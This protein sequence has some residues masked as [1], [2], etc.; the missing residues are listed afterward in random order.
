ML[1]LEEMRLW[2]GTNVGEEVS[3]HHSYYMSK[4]PNTHSLPAG[5]CVKY[6]G[7]CGKSS[8]K[9]QPNQE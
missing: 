9:P 3:L 4:H 7:E 2:M 6:L 5:P 8:D 1:A